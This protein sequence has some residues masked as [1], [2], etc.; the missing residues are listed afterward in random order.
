MPV[1]PKKLISVNI[2]ED[3]TGL[4]LKNDDSG[5]KVACI[6]TAESGFQE[7]D[8]AMYMIIPFT[9][10]VSTMIN[11]FWRRDESSEWRMYPPSEQPK[12]YFQN[13]LITDRSILCTSEGGFVYNNALITKPVAMKELLDENDESFNPKQYS[14]TEYNEGFTNFYDFWMESVG[15]GNIAVM[16]GGIRGAL[17]MGMMARNM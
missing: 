7:L 17:G 13:Q 11:I 8:V 9:D 12:R 5:I 3:F 14:E 10:K 2:N 4:E 6:R 16:N 1:I 15:K